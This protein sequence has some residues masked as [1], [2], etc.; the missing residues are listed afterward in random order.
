[1]YSQ[2]PAPYFAKPTPERDAAVAILRRMIQTRLNGRRGPCEDTPLHK[3]IL[4][5][6]ELN[7]AVYS[8]SHRV[9][10]PKLFRDG[11]TLS[12]GKRFAVLYRG[13]V[14]S[15]AAT[16]HEANIAL[17]VIEECTVTGINS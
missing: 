8:R 10:G 6:T 12:S 11:D 14:I 9:Y 15:Y 7:A 5:A 1:M 4:R 3:L 13:S 2:Q 16:L 17:D